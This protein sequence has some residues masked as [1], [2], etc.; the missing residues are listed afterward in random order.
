MVGEKDQKLVVV[1]V[2]VVVVVVAV[3]VV[4]PLQAM[5]QKCNLIEEQHVKIGLR[6]TA[7]LI[8][9]DRRLSMF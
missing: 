1:V 9:L 3:V 5:V 8:L 7:N 2:A 6:Q 4:M